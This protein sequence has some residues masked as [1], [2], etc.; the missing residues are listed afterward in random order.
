MFLRSEHLDRHCA[1]LQPPGDDAQHLLHDTD[2][3]NPLAELAQAGDEPVDAHGEV[4][5]ALAV[6]ERQ[7]VELPHEALDARVLHTVVAARASSS[8]RPTLP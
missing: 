8:P 6:A 7:V 4:A 5:D 3:L 2:V 1:L